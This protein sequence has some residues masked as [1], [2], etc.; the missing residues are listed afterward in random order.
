MEAR[1]LVVFGGVRPSYVGEEIGKAE[2]PELAVRSSEG[3]EGGDVVASADG[4]KDPDDG[5]DL[6]G[7][8]GHGEGEEGE[9]IYL[10]IYPP[11]ILIIIHSHAGHAYTAYACVHSRLTRCASFSFSL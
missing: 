6:A 1:F 10:I 7:L 8:E 3:G 9:N 2:E 11:N 5:E 4:S